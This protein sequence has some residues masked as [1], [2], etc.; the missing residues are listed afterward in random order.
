M[1]E[2]VNGNRKLF[3]RKVSKA[4]GGKVENSNRIKDG[5]ERLTLEEPEVRRIWK[6]YYENLYNI[7]LRNRL[8]S[9]CVALTGFGEV[10]ILEEAD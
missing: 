9:T 2:D 5:Y 3:W 7:E 4:I 1:N 8:Q 10:T 6:E